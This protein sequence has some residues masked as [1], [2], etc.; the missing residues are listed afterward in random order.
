MAIFTCTDVTVP[1]CRDAHT[2]EWQSLGAA[3]RRRRWKGRRTIRIPSAAGWGKPD[4]A[5]M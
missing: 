1:V 2:R 4:A 5:D 3:C